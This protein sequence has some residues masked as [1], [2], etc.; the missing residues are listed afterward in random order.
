MQYSSAYAIIVDM[1]LYEA[2]KI[3]RTVKSALSADGYKLPPSAD[4]D[5]LMMLLDRLDI[6]KFLA[7]KI[8]HARTADKSSAAFKRSFHY[9]AF[10]RALAAVKNG[11]PSP[12]TYMSVMMLHKTVCGDL[13]V[14]AGKPRTAELLTD[15]NAHTDPKY[16]AG[17]LKAIIA[18]MNDTEIAPTISKE[19]FAGY[20][21]HYMRELLI[22]H[23]FDLGSELT[24]RLFLVMF[25]KQKGFSLLLYRSTPSTIK[26]A[27]DKAFKTDDI[28]P[29]YKLFLN[30]LSYERTTAPA[31]TRDSAP[32]TRREL[33]R[34]LRHPTRKTGESATSASNRNGNGKNT[35]ASAKT[36]E[37]V[38]KRA[39]RLQQ[40]I[41]KL[42]EQL[43]ELIQPLEKTD[44]D[45]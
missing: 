32:R 23:P 42:N 10:F 37:D 30:C 12:M 11:M 33:A 2:N 25:C 35:T 19:D 45:E 7:Q 5:G 13:N 9:L 29:L 34:D 38:L 40:K 1:E 27:E 15:G 26:D 14:D 16:I 4:A 3:L 24:L 17:S 21:S 39:I 18:K 41:S 22:M 8:K 28:T 31:Q 6:D 43:T 36:K 20:L 44:G